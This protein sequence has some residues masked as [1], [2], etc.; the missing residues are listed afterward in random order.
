MLLSFILYI[1]LDEI[2]LLNLFGILFILLESYKLTRNQKV[3]RPLWPLFQLSK[4]IKSTICYRITSLVQ[5]VPYDL[6]YPLNRMFVFTFLSAQRHLRYFRRFTSQT[7]TKQRV[8][9]VPNNAPYLSKS[10]CIH[11]NIYLF[12]H[13]A[14]C[15]QDPVGLRWSQS[16][17]RYYL[18]CRE[19][20]WEK[21]KTI[22]DKAAGKMNYEVCTAGFHV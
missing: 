14:S 13:I 15:V 9:V 20:C 19:H 21:L 11:N 2:S 22:S 16:V 7:P 3:C 4:H 6:Y 18:L 5:Y 8:P 12:I 17:S 1:I 10:K